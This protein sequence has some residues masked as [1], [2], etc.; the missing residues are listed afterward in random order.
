MRLVWVLDHQEHRC[1]WCLGSWTTKSID[2][3][4][5]WPPGPTE[6]VEMQILETPN[7]NPETE[8][9]TGSVT[10]VAPP[11]DDDERRRGEAHRNRCD[12][13]VDEVPVGDVQDGAR[14][15]QVVVE[16]RARSLSCFSGGAFW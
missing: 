3:S 13:S 4:G 1:E 12:S 5:V 9:P 6:R 11:I 2:V 15:S 16:A 8:S 10:R 7:T 14:H